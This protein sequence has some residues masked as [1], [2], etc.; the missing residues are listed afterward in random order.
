MSLPPICFSKI[1]WTVVSASFAFTV[2]MFNVAIDISHANAAE[3]D[4]RTE[5][6]YSVP[7]VKEDISEI[8]QDVK[9]IRDDLTEIKILLESQR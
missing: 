8:K 5:N 3:L 2:I 1:F 4:K 9:I 6:V 7:A